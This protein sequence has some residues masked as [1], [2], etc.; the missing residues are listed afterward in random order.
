MSKTI[1]H[2]LAKGPDRGAPTGDVIGKMPMK[3]MTS[4]VK[5]YHL[6]RGKKSF[7]ALFRGKV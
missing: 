2:N 5:K 1:K 7:K 4:S 6:S 3:P